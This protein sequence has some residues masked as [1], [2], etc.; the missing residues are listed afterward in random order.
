MN[1]KNEKERRTSPAVCK[2]QRVSEE[3]GRKA[4]QGM[5]NGKADGTRWH[6]SRGLEISGGA[7]S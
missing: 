7:S 3:E 5:K 6:S 4:I 2:G 1:E